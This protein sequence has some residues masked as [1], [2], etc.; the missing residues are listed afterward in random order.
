MG[1]ALV[2]EAEDEVRSFVASTLRDAGWH[3]AISQSE[4][5][6]AEELEN[7]DAIV[8]DLGAAVK[9]GWLGAGSHRPRAKL[10]VSS[11]VGSFLDDVREQVDAVL[12]TPTTRAS[13]LAAVDEVQPPPV[14]T[15][16]RID[17]PTRQRWIDDRGLR[18]AR[19]DP[20]L[21]AIAEL[22]A[23]AASAP[24][25]LVTLVDAQQQIFLGHS[26]LPTDL[27]TA[28]GTP[29]NWAFCQHAVNSDTPLVIEDART[30]PTLS[31]NPLVKMG[32]A[33]SYA[34]VPIDLP[35]VGPIGTVCVLSSEPRAFDDAQLASL[36]LA[37]RLA[38]ERIEKITRAHPIRVVGSPEPPPILRPG[39][40]IEGKYL[41]TAALGE[42]GQA[43][44]YL[45]RDRLL[46]QLVAIKVQLTGADPSI[47]YEA[48]ALA[49]LR[50]K[51]IVQLHGWGRLPG[52]AIY[53][54]LE[55]VEGTTLHAHL[56]SLG[57]RK[58]LMGMREVL[59]ITHAIGGALATLHSVGLLHG[60]V[61]PANI[62][63]DFALAR[64]L[65]IDF[66]LGVRIDGSS[67]TSGG[68]HGWSA[69]EQFDLER[70]PIAGPELDAYSLACVAYAMIVGRMPFQGSHEEQLALQR[71]GAIRS[72]ATARDELPETIDDVFASALSGDPTQR[73]A[74]PQA[75]ANAL[76]AAS[77]SR[78]SFMP[79][80]SWT[81]STESAVPRSRGVVFGGIRRSLRMLVGAEEEAAVFASMSPRARLVFEQVEGDDELYPTSAY[82]EYLQAFIGDDR[83]RLDR[84][85]TLVAKA[86]AHDAL[87]RMNVSRTPET[88]LH[89][90]ADL[91]HYYH[92]WGETRLRRIGSHEAE[93]ELTT[94]ESLVPMMCRFSGAIVASSLAAMGRRASVIQTAC[95]AEGAESCRFDVRWSSR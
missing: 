86:I 89:V 64:S 73:Y 81:G 44:V 48:R 51:S 6:T 78:L 21:M 54:V 58:E 38:A 26:G 95:V 47:L 79:R 31:S 14:S 33:T 41:I 23:R 92:E 52:G 30:H 90:T 72:V 40:M 20:E 70:P 19:S 91:V 66:G 50:H 43:K 29:R 11:A 5:P 3:V 35:D 32:L 82:V 59:E 24:V 39:D 85:A 4:R 57:R 62:M 77:E 16:L 87:R 76:D 18:A 49:Q 83:E 80:T 69:P 1:R 67:R 42:G 13:V 88:L 46:G 15:E 37:A 34:G 27:D 8:T 60:D 68:T 25:G 36:H 9:N 22:A 61:K 7:V 55:Y 71:Q 28:G 2:V 10:I 94:P 63:L 65:L 45:A 84:L 74:S 17:R 56:A 12:P 93:L 75:F 53:L